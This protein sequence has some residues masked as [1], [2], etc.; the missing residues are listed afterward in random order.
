MDKREDNTSVRPQ[1]ML[2]KV[3]PRYRLPV[4]VTS[5]IYCPKYWQCRVIRHIWHFLINSHFKRI[6][7]Y[8]KVAV[9]RVLNISSLLRRNLKLFSVF[10]CVMQFKISAALENV[11]EYTTGMQLFGAQIVYTMRTGYFPEIRRWEWGWR[12][13]TPPPHPE[14]RFV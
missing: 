5:T 1:P 8:F 7:D 13:Q 2:C 9:K 10:L 3:C 12:W 6:S 4:T 14:P 11:F